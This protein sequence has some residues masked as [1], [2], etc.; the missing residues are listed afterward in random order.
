MNPSF[1]GFYWV[2]PGFSGFNWVLP[3]F[4]GFNWVLLGFTGYYVVL[5]GCTLGKPVMEVDDFFWGY[6]FCK[7][8][9]SA[10]VEAGRNRI[11]LNKSPVKK[12]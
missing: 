4:T 12:N 1:T 5:L 8:N 7:K 11:T 3:G 6:F 9:A 10:C 2:L